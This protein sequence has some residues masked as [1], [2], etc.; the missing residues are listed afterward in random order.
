MNLERTRKLASELAE[1]LQGIE[2]LE[3]L[4]ASVAINFLVVG[5]NIS[6]EDRARY[7]EETR[8][9]ILAHKDLLLD[10]SHLDRNGQPLSDVAEI[11]TPDVTVDL[12]AEGT[13]MPEKAQGSFQVEE[14][15]R[16]KRADL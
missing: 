14:R 2:S 4:Y 12:R 6:D 11:G 13:G 10:V 9:F 7:A 3:G 16:D 15:L 1:H 5:N 8:K